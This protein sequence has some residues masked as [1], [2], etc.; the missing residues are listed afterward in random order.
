MDG[1]IQTPNQR[2]IHTEREIERRQ[3]LE[4]IDETAGIVYFKR[5]KVYEEKEVYNRLRKNTNTTS[6]VKHE[7]Q[8]FKHHQCSKT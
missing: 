8:P 4:T 2:H 7:L 1:H 3:K 6:A 5:E